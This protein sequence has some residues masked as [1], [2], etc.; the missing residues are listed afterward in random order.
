[1]SRTNV[2]IDDA[3]LDWVMKRY[4]FHTKREAINYALKRLRIAPMSR[5]E[6]LSLQGIGWEGDLDSMRAVES[7]VVI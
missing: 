3:D 7:P 6:M 2:D 1:M 4:R 5:E